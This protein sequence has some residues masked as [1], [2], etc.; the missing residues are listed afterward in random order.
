MAFVHGKLVNAQE[1]R[2]RQ[3]SCFVHLSS[4]VL[5]G[6]TGNALEAGLHKTWTHSSGDSDMSH[7]LVTGLFAHL[8]TQSCS[9]SPF[10]ATS[11]IGFGKGGLTRFT[12]KAPFPQDQLHLILS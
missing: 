10:P 4:V 3:R 9:G 7:C 8:F 12:A 5:N 6:S 1:A 11:G 2:C